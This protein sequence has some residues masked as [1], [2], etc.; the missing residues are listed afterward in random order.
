M[1]HL[2][3]ATDLSFPDVT[4][5][6]R[7]VAE[8]NIDKIAQYELTR[9]LGSGGMSRVY[10]GRHRTTEQEVA[11]KIL[12]P[13]MQVRKHVM[14]RFQSEFRIARKLF[15]PNLVRA[16][17]FGFEQ[18]LAYLVL[19]Y[20]PG[21]SLFQLIRD[22]MRLPEGDAVRYL[23]QVAQG[24]QVAHRMNLVHR[25]IKPA[26]I[27]ITH[28]GDAKVSDLGLAKDLLAAE[29][30]TRSGASLGTLSY[31]APEQFM[32]ARRADSRAD[33]Y[34]LGITL[35]HVLTGQLPFAGGQMTMLQ[36]KLANQFVRPR[37]LMPSLS[38][39]MNRLIIQCLQPNPDNRPATCGEFLQMLETAGD[40][41][42]PTL[43]S[44]ELPAI[45]PVDNRR[46]EARFPIE[47][48]SVC[49]MLMSPNKESWRAK[50]VDVSPG[51][52]HLLVDRRFEVGSL[53]AVDVD[54]EQLGETMSL[55]LRVTWVRPSDE[56]GL[57]RV[58]GRFHRR[59]RPSE[60][61]QLVQRELLTVMVC[62]S[63]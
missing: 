37:D 25:D 7:V 56:K 27:L 59:I 23:S 28:T 15:H 31:M 63:D 21:R 19:E 44:F 52:A 4:N 6:P 11:V 32:N 41:L 43:P 24:L 36:K 35:Y 55:T 34:S 54:D 10:H 38:N 50:M 3:P 39:G 2:D 29:S 40:K 22:K 16:L 33:I 60:L 26:N 17:D 9:L 18:G 5:N 58:G 51:G 48:R 13:E 14:Q 42:A 62:E 1:A 47:L 57:W 46:A 53:I 61:Q 8:Q 45:A 49:K 12:R 30:I 20:I